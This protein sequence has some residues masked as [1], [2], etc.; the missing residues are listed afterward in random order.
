MTG[1]LGGLVVGALVWTFLEYTLHR[2]AFHEKKL[3][4]RVARE[5][6]KHHAKVDWFAPMSVKATMAVVILTPIVALVAMVGG[7][8]A[9]ALPVGIV[10]SWIAYEIV[11]RRIHVSAPMGP[12]GRWA[13]RHHLA[14]HF[15]HSTKNHGV[16]SPIWDLVFGTYVPI[17][18]VTVPR[19]HAR[20]F[21]WLL[22]DASAEK[23]AI[24]ATWTPEYRIV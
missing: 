13:R 22:E 17:R 1:I 4:N 19:L 7:A 8:F 9:A 14:H 3:G 24:A 23:P 16:T 6:L 11:H 15:G 10:G 12:Y 5:H 20:K 18:E 21:P 2:F